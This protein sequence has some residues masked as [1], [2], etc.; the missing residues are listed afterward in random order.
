MEDKKLYM[1]VFQGAEDQPEQILGVEMTIERAWQIVTGVM[2]QN[3]GAN[4]NQFR[5]KEFT[6]QRDLKM[7]D[8]QEQK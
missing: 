1:A 5:V 2:S 7:L 8:Y 6:Y 3:P 4:A